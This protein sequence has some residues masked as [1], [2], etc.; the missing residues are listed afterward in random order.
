MD[1]LDRRLLVVTGK[2]G[3][4]KTTVASALA[5]QAAS[6]GK[7]VLLCELDAKGDL[8]ASLQGVSARASAPLSF[9]PREV[10][11]RLHAMVM[12]PE[13][14]LKEY[15]RIYLRLPL[16]TRIGL[17]SNAFDFLANAAPGV[18]EIV[19]IG[20]LAHEVR[21]RHYDIVVV[22]AT[23]SGHIVGLLRAP[24][25][26]NELVKAGLLRSQTAWILDILGDPKLTGVVAVA[27]PE[28][29]PVSE[30]AD[31]FANLA[32]QTNI[33]VQMVVVNRVL[34]VPFTQ[35]ESLEFAALRQDFDGGGIQTGPT[36]LTPSRRSSGSADLIARL[37]MR[38][39]SGPGV[40]GVPHGRSDGV[41]HG[42]LAGLE[43]RESALLVRGVGLAEDLRTESLQHLAALRTI[44]GP[45]PVALVAQLFGVSAGLP[46]TMAVA[47]ILSE[48][49][50]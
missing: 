27:T 39:R 40:N 35:A 41:S 31:L 46:A 25:A 45:I 3:V 1:I 50:S 23:A 4:G 19:T 16:V 49:L 5:W 32:S 10:H 48:E 12:D 37:A 26:I 9:A 43:D 24:Q 15:L 34:P 30:T 17:L 44:A 14:S 29:L 42:G 7:R 33:S 18:R 28:E 8:L 6:L 47:E 21:E 20:K 11:P 13:E 2:G 38:S 36:G 22:D